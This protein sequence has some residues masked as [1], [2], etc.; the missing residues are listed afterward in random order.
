MRN[1]AMPAIAVSWYMATS[2]ALVF[3]NKHALSHGLPSP[4][5]LTWWQ[6]VVT[7]PLIVGMRRLRDPLSVGFEL[8][9]S[10]HVAPLALVYSS[11][12]VTSN[13]CLQYVHASS[14]RAPAAQLAA[15]P[16]R[17]GCAPSRAQRLRARCTSSARS[18]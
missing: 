18:C 11:M 14:Y 9:T 13:A 3:F 15:S 6:M 7:L 17:H 16:S 5:A 10:M 4:L 1:S 12:V 2:I 8:R